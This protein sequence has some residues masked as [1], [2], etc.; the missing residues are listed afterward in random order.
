MNTHKEKIMQKILFMTALTS[1]IGLSAMA[2]EKAPLKVIDTE[3]INNPKYVHDRQFHK[4]P[5]DYSKVSWNT[6]AAK[7][8]ARAIRWYHEHSGRDLV[9]EAKAKQGTV[10]E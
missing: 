9:Q 3:K 4:A 5:P 7:R 10:K 1:L 2:A 8:K 6:H